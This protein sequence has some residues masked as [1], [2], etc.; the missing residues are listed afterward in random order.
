M[1]KNNKLKT[2]CHTRRSLQAKERWHAR[3]VADLSL[4]RSNDKLLEAVPLPTGCVDTM[5]ATDS[6]PQHRHRRRHRLAP[7]QQQP[8]HRKELPSGTKKVLHE[9]KVRR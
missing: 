1:R 5:P 7:S 6:H 8:Q 4:S 3:R 2:T 9:R